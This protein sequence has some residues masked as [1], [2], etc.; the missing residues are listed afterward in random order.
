MLTDIRNREEGQKH[1]E[2]IRDTSLQNT[3]NL[4]LPCLNQLS[5]MQAKDDPKTCSLERQSLD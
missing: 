5:L 1:R 3:L 2:V 4:P